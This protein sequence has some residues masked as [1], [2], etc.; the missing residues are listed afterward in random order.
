MSPTPAIIF[1][2]GA[3]HKPSCYDKVI[4]ILQSSGQD[5]KCIPVT[6][7]STL[8]NPL[9][10]FKDD[11]DAARTAIT[12]ETTNGRDV[13]VVSHSYG[14]M[15]GNSA[16]KD[17]TPP[18]TTSSAS[19]SSKHGYVKAL[20]LIASGFTI[21]GLSFMDPFFGIPPPFF[22]VNQD[23]GYAEL[24]AN[25]RDFFYH[26][27]E[28]EEA[29]YWVGELTTQSLKALFEGG[30]HAYGG[31]QDVPTFYIGT[32]EDKGLPVV[33]QRI[34]VAAAR[35]QGAA[36]H[37]VEMQSSHSP[38]LSMPEDV[39]KVLLDAVEMM[40]ASSSPQASRSIIHRLQ[41]T[42]KRKGCEAPIVRLTAPATWYRYGIP[43]FFGRI[44]GW[45]MLGFYSL[46]GLWKR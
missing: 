45:S 19:S 28:D 2:P 11:I 4:S 38:F 16:I 9:A 44:I 23:T 37:H 17:L 14:G 8:D 25:P 43:F 36:V 21:T 22:R 20:V 10:T 24:V 6:L 27:V 46:R 15:V 39:A 40:R 41:E 35:A 32:V 18:K 7:P 30:E 3:W 31:W 34:Q 13:I 29:E 1:I 12:T 42:P 26:D 33:A 5:I